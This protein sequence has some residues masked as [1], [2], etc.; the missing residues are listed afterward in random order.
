MDFFNRAELLCLGL[1]LTG[2][3]CK[4]EVAS[5]GIMFICSFMKVGLL[6]QK[7]KQ[8]KLTQTS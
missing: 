7:L 8:E 2:R 5:D 4:V 1:C 3:E 6:V